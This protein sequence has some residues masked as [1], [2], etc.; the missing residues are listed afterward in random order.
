MA[1]NRTQAVAAV[2]AAVRAVCAETVIVFAKPPQTV[3]PPAIVVGRP[4]EVRYA[5]A[6]LSVDEADLPVAC[7]GPADGEDLVD[8]LIAAVRHAVA[9]DWSLG[10]A[11]QH[12]RDTLER[13][14]RNLNVAGVDILQAEILLTIRM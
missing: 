5:V 7:V 12:C 9:V 11:V 2:V 4:V 3:N 6:A 10:G 13:N 14:W 8:E 1:W